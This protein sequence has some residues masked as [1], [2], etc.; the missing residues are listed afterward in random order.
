MSGYTLY[1]KPGSGSMV[2]EAALRLIGIGFDEVRVDETAAPEF[3]ALNP[4]GKVPVLKLACGP[5]I[6]ESAAILMT[7][8]DMFPEARLLPPHGTPAHASAT[9]WLVFMATN[10]YPAARRYYYPDIHTTDPG[11]EAV[12]AIKQQAALDMGREFAQ[13][14]AAIQGPFLLGQTITITDVYAAMLADWF[15]PA[16]DLP[17]IAALVNAVLENP[18]AAEAWRHHGFGK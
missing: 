6:A 13:L 17:E 12:N 2:V 4:A 9:Q 16:K 15:D 14:A 10:I 3:L 5:V 18:A 1:W 8:D 7:L 11:P